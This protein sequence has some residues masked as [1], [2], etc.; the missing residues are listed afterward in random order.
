VSVLVVFFVLAI[1][2]SGN[3]RKADTPE[4]SA[5]VPL[6]GTSQPELQTDGQESGSTFSLKDF[7]RSET[8]DGKTVWE[9]KGKNMKYFPEDNIV[10]IDNGTLWF[11]NSADETITL[12]CGQARLLIVDASLKQ[13]DTYDG[14][15]LVYNDRV[16][17]TARKAVY[18]KEEGSI[19]A[20]GKVRI[21][22]DNMEITGNK[23][24]ANVETREITLLQNVASV[25]NPEAL[26]DG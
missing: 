22:S 17:I 23:L 24:R 5:S 19:L 2:L 1:I 12:T 26:N 15:K 18:N 6:N 8:K 7:H 20:P 21:V 11:F 25:I 14:V 4:S 13:A 16:T 3:I 9:V 10:Q